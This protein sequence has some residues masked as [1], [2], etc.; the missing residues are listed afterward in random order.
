MRDFHNKLLQGLSE[1]LRVSSQQRP[2]SVTAKLTAPTATDVVTTMRSSLMKIND[3]LID[4]EDRQL[5]AELVAWL[6]TITKASSKWHPETIAEALF[7]EGM[8]SPYK[9]NNYMDEDE[10]DFKDIL[11]IHCNLKRG[12]IKMVL[13]KLKALDQENRSTGAQGVEETKA[14]APPAVEET[15]AA[16]PPGATAGAP[17]GGSGGGAGRGRGLGGAGGGGGGGSKGFDFGAPPQF[18]DFDLMAELAAAIEFF[19]SIG[20]VA[21]GVTTYYGDENDAANNLYNNGG[22]TLN[23]EQ[24]MRIVQ[25][26]ITAGKLECA[27]L[28]EDDSLFGSDG[29]DIGPVQTE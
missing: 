18:L 5:K 14:A 24:A 19:Q 25:I 4:A 28:D 15:K 1:E 10:D 21:N 11:K 2:S 6:S 23:I 29:S 12:Q 9:M 20:T 27:L 13:Q 3:D 16:T 26:L 7:E 8:T 17:T 22:R